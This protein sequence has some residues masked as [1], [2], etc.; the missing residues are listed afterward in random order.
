MLLQEFRAFGVEGVISSGFLK[1]ILERL[2][3]F[4]FGDVGF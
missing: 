1:G 2:C 4:E 3:K